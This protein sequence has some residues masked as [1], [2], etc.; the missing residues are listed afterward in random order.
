MPAL[1]EAEARIRAA[2]LRHTTY[3]VFLD[4]TADPVRTRTEIRFGCAE[5]GTATFADLST[6]AVLSAV[7][8]GRTL[9][10]SCRGSTPPTCSRSR[11]RWPIPWPGTA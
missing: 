8:N 10:W 1:T 7:L 6:Q 9:G 4:L 2:L 11:P 3:D 5:P